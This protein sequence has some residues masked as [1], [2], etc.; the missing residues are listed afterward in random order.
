LGS[1]VQGFIVFFFRC[2]TGVDPASVRPIDS[3]AKISPR[4]LFFIA[5]EREA[6]ANQTQAQFEA[7]GLPKE[8][9]L[10]PQVGHGGYGDRWPQ[11]YE[12][13]IVDFFDQNFLA[14]APEVVK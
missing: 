13:R 10:V 1:L 2:Y 14:A 8:L 12:R 3:V 11:E 9:W 7:A 4:P 6:E 5:G